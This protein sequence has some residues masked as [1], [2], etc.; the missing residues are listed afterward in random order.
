MTHPALSLRKAVFARLAGDA[1]LVALLGGSLVFDHV[2]RGRK[3]PY[4]VI[5]E[6]TS[7]PIDA[8]PPVGHEH[9]LAVTAWSEQPGLAEASALI[10]AAVASLAAM[11]TT[12]DGHRLVNLV[13]LATELRHEREGR[14]SRAT[15]RLRAVTEAI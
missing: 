7:Q 8:G 13:T 11:P 3:P 4:L 10:E 1:V 15:A 14:L 6:S 5:G 2:P 9:R 12:L